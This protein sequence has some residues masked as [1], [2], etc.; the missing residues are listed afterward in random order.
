MEVQMLMKKYLLLWSLDKIAEAFM[1]GKAAGR[2]LI[3]DLIRSILK[4]LVD[5]MPAESDIVTDENFEEDRYSI[6]L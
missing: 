2:Q 3:L 4:V 1:S 6:L 5:D